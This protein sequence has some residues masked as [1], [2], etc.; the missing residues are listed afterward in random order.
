MNSAAQA[1]RL[2]LIALTG[3]VMLTACASG[4]R[5]NISLIPA[6][7][8]AEQT[9]KDGLFTQP[10]KWERKKP[11]CDGECPTLKVD[12]IVFPGI[13]KLS[14]L[15]DH[16]LAVMTGVGTLQAQPYDT[17]KQYEDYFWKTAAPRD[18]TLLSAKTRYRNKNLTAIELNTWQY[19]TGAAHGIAATQFLNWDNN[20]GQILGMAHILQPGKHQDYV[21]A[22]RQAHSQWLAHQPDAQHDP[23]TFNRIWPFQPSDNFA[24]TDAGL[25]VKYDSYQIAPYSSGQPELLIPYSSLQ[26]ILKLEYMPAKT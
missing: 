11:G 18:S 24:F 5:D 8:V 26:G 15:I 13:T 19:Y 23:A 21:A 25:V 9:S 20:A 10:V 6:D 17:I 7:Q 4:P 3:A 12:S 1:A 14:E 2:V 16:A 22:L